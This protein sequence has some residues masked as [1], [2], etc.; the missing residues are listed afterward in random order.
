[1][2]HGGNA[3]SVAGKLGLSMCPR[4]DLDFS[5]N[6]NP[7]GPPP[8]LRQILLQGE[9]AAAS[10]P[11]EFAA[12]ACGA[13]AAA[14]GIETE[15]V[16]VGNG[17]TEI[18]GWIL[19][20][21][22]PRGA[23]LI[24]PCYGGYQEA[25]DAH[26]IRAAG[27]ATLTPENQFRFSGPL[28]LPE[29]GDLLFIGSPNNPTGGLVSPD[30]LTDLAWN[31]PSA[32]IVVDAS[33]VDFV[34]APFDGLPHGDACPKNLIVV[35]SLTKFFCIPG[36]RLGM[37][38]GHPDV[39]EH[40]KRVRLPWTVNGLAQAIAPHLYAD[41]EYLE[42]SRTQT[43]LLRSLFETSLQSIRGLTVYPSDAN[44]LLVGL[45]EAWPV[46][47]LQKELLQRGIL[48]RSCESFE[49]L[50]AG[51]CRLAVRPRDEQERLIDNLRSL[52]AAQ[53]PVA[54]GP[55]PKPPAIMVVGTTSNAGKTI[56]VAGLCRLLARRGLSVAPFKAQNMALNSYV[57]EEG[58]EMGRAQVTQ[59]YAAGV[60][61]HTDMN[62]ILLKPLGENGSQ[63]IVNGQPIGNFKAREYYSMKTRMRRAAHAA[64][65]RLAAQHEILVLEGAGS[66]AEINLMAEDFVNMD[67]AAYARARTVLVADIDRGGVFATILGTI[68]LLPPSH[69]RLLAGIIINKFRGDASLLDSGIRDIEVMTGVPVLGVL[70]YMHDL[71]IEDEDSLGLERARETDGAVLHVTVIRLPR[72]SNFTDYLAMERDSGISVR[73]ADK[74]EMIGNPDLIILPGTKNTRADLKWLHAGGIG[75]WL[76]KAR[77]RGIPVIGIC[78]GFQMLGISVIDKTG[79]EGEAGKTPG[80]GLLPVTTRI[81]RRKELAQVEGVTASSFPFAERGTRYTGY[82][83]HAGETDRIQDGNAPLFVTRRRKAAVHEHAGAVSTDGLVFGCY[84]HGL[85]DDAT[86][87]TALWRRLCDRKGIAHDAVAVS[88]ENPSV[89]FDRLAD[90]IEQNIRLDFLG[91]VVQGAH[92]CS[93]DRCP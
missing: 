25:C 29:N 51:Y 57:T 38:W 52:C 92:R 18:F 88:Q 93:S 15:Q 44:F 79:I 77:E 72:I 78:G 19:Q 70:P 64:Y 37:A 34:E 12:P 3:D 11:N 13:L 56:I 48:I 86:L 61:P 46:S 8:V 83:I 17:S 23:V 67:M 53:L 5:V 31:N 40:I 20:A 30:V 55:N 14:H 2:Q 27:I 71:R 65:D 39:M 73:Y 33:F 63:V 22:R 47:R 6:L 82:E 80:L 26:G 75:D 21:L 54:R 41:R 32:M 84:I 50:G 76:S 90:L 87:R 35:K 58:G 49:G 45:P 7:V 1:M 59:A 81:T 4:V 62:P 74:V 10:Y 36:I 69:R 60:R 16:I 24:G 42:R 66:P 89:A 68:N 91:D 28:K 9:D 43:R 85:F